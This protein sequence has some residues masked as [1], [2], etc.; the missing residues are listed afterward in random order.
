M[1]ASPM[2]DPARLAAAYEALRARAVGDPVVGRPAPG[3]ALLY[4]HGLPAWLAQMSQAA[5]ATT[6]TPP[7]TTDRPVTTT[8]TSAGYAAEAVL[9]VASMVLASRAG[10]RS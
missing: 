2:I 3:L 9:V 8:V 7:S 6:A 10:D 5:V 4:R 1:A